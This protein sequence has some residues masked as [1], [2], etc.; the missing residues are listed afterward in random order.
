MP[1]HDFIALKC[2]IEPQESALKRTGG[3][4]CLAPEAVVPED[5]ERIIRT[6][7]SDQ[8]NTSAQVMG[9]LDDAF[10]GIQRLLIAE[11][12]VCREA[13]AD[14]DD[15]AVDRLAVAKTRG[16]CNAAGWQAS[17]ATQLAAADAELVDPCLLYPYSCV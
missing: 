2:S 1:L 13:L 3:Q 17:G 12:G 7:T 9:Q 14:T 4:K 15:L 8:R 10:H 6:G 11:H 5:I 16:T